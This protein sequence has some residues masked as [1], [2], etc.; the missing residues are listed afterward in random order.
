M[1]KFGRADQGGVPYYS[2]DNEPALWGGTHPRIHPQSLTYKELLDKSEA[3]AKAVKAVDPSARVM[4]SES[5]GAMEM[6]KCYSGTAELHTR[7]LRLERLCRQIRLG[8]SGLPGR[9]EGPFD[10][11]RQAVDRRAG[12]PLV[13]RGQR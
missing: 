12:H 10:G 5:F 4:G 2:L 8:G 13:P 9:D 7:M 11:G 6:W 1:Q 3:L